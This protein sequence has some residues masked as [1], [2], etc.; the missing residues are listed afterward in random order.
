VR[1][2]VI[3]TGQAR[4]FR[5]CWSNQW[6][7]LYRKLDNPIFY[8]CVEDDEQADD[9]ELLWERSDRVFIRKVKRPETVFMPPLDAS[10]HSASVVKGSLGNTSRGLWMSNEAWKFFESC[11]PGIHEQVVISRPD[12]F[13]RSFVMPYR[14]EPT[15]IISLWWARSGGLNDRLAFAGLEAAKARLTT[16]ERIP[17]LLDMGCAFHG[18]SLAAGALELAGC[19][20]SPVLHAWMSFVRLDGTVVNPDYTPD[21]LAMMIQG[22]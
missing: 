4:T 19:R 16:Y 18:E 20:I 10:A 14:P 6:W 12:M 5:Q 15:E 9:M 2:A 8:A 17:E 13:F 21:E 22:I 3:I 1:T 7:N 11:S